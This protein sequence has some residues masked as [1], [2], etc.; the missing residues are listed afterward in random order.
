[1]VL[2]NNDPHWRMKEVIYSIMS[3]IYMTV[4]PSKPFNPILGETYEAFMCL[5]FEEL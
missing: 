4:K 2:N 3:T 5:N 1:M